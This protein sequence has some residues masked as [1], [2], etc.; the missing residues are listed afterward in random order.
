[1]P[2]WNK[3]NDDVWALRSNGPCCVDTT[4]CP[5]ETLMW[6]RTTLVKYLHGWEVYEYAQPISDLQIL[7]K[8][9]QVVIQSFA[10]SPLHIAMLFLLNFLALRSMTVWCLAILLV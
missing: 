9:F 6:L 8:L 10:L 5:A 1:M 7:K 2:G 3:L 4:L